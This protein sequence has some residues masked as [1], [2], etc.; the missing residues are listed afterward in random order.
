MPAITQ[1]KTKLK[2][3]GAFTEND[4]RGQAYKE[5]RR[6]DQRR[7]RL[8]TLLGNATLFK[9]GAELSGLAARQS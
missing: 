3:S 4:L 8:R 5:I 9:R 6:G 2:F 1:N 7:V